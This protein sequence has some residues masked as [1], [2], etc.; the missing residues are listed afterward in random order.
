MLPAATA[1]YVF[2]QFVLTSIYLNVGLAIFNLIP[3]PPL[4]GSKIFISILPDSV[5]YK[6]LEY[7]RY[8][9]IL[10]ILLLFSGFL[11]GPLGFLSGLLVDGLLW[12]AQKILFWM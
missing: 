7:E 4:D 12:L 11:N 9:Y 1:S 3:V 6:I 5:Y 8:G 10:L 2:L